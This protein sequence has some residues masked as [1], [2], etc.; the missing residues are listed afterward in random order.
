MGERC[1][2]RE[3]PGG[4]ASADASEFAG[5]GAVGTVVAEDKAVAVEHFAVGLSK[6]AAVAGQMAVEL[7]DIAA[8]VG[9]MA[10]E[11]GETAAEAEDTVVDC[12]LQDSSVSLATFGLDNYPHRRSAFECS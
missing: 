3:L 11:P 1:S 8:E 7:V 9:G 10:A 12:V 6:T 4:Q 2:A 5:A